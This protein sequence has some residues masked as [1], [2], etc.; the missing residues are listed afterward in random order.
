MLHKRH[1][2]YLVL[3]TAL[4][5][6][7]AALPASA[8]AHHGGIPC[9]GV[10]DFVGHMGDADGSFHYPA[11]RSAEHVNAGTFT[12]A[13]DD[14]SSTQNFRLRDLT[15][16]GTHV[17]RATS[18]PDQSEECWTVTLDVGDYEWISDGDQTGYL[19][20]LVTAHPNPNPPPPPPPPS[21]A[22]PPPPP[23]PPAQPDLILTVGPD[24]RIA[25]FY[26]DGRPVTNLPPGTYTIQVHDLSATHNFHLTGPGV[27]EKTSVDDI[28]HPVWRV[29]LRAGKYTFKCDV[30]PTIKGSFTVSTNAPPVPKCKVPRVIGK[31]LSKA[32]RSI[33]AAHC[34]VGRVRYLRSKRAKGRIVRQAPGA[35]RTLAVGTR[36]NLVV[37]RGPG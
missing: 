31:G 17:N 29:T 28:E 5:G 13:I 26:A 11:G 2:F 7:V 27:D 6:V 34:S 36:V 25:A 35:G 22:G 30:H 10:P 19:R 24:P 33:R 21:P 32:R 9:M 8:H 12:L 15:W 37:S 14:T 23:P 4:A 3:V 1:A 18:V 16:Q 20:G